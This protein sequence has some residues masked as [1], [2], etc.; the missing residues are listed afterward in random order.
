MLPLEETPTA[1]ITL[2]HALTAGTGKPLFASLGIEFYQNVNG[3]DYI[4]MNSSYNALN[5]MKVDL[6]IAN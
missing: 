4:L 2:S 5:L 1:A 3:I 6:S